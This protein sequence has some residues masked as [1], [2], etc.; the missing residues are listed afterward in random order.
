MRKALAAAGVL[1][2]ALLVGVGAYVSQADPASPTTAAT[3]VG[4]STADDSASP[5]AS[6]SATPQVGDDNGGLVDRDLRTEPGDD[7][8]LRV[9]GDDSDGDAYDDSGRGGHDDPD[10]D[11]GRGGDDDGPD[12]D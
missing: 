4:A 8:D 10:D 12:H 3:A 11:S 9:V 7:R 5:S 1:A 6:P 2:A